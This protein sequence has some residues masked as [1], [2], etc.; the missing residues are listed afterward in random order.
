MAQLQIGDRIRVSNWFNTYVSTIVRVTKTKAIG[1]TKRADGTIFTTEFRRE[2]YENL[3][4]IYPYRLERYD[5]TRR[6]LITK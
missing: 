4:I 6:K 5:Q 2:Y 1:E 3:K